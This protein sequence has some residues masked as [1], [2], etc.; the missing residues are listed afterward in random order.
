MQCVM[1]KGTGAGDFKESFAGRFFG[2]ERSFFFDFPQLVH[3]SPDFLPACG[4]VMCPKSF[5]R[6]CQHLSEMFVGKPE[7]LLHPLLGSH[8]P[9]AEDLFP[10]DVI[11]KGL[12]AVGSSGRLSM[13]KI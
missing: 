4:F 2:Y 6:I 3:L 12:N 11:L 9:G 13:L 5:H 8:R 1:R 10:M 7:Y